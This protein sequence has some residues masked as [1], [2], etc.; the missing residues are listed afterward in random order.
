MMNFFP[1]IFLIKIYFVETIF[2]QKQKQ[3][4]FDKM[5]FSQNNYFFKFKIC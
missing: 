2:L 5:F 1:G 3:K 4:I